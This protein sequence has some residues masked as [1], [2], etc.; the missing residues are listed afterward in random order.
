MAFL[1]RL[2]GFFQ[3]GRIFRASDLIGQVSAQTAKIA[4]DGTYD[5][6]TRE[7]VP[8]RIESTKSLRTLFYV[9]LAADELP[10]YHFWTVPNHPDPVRAAGLMTR[11]AEVEESKT[12]E[13]H[14]MA[15]D[16]N[17][18]D[19]GLAGSSIDDD[20]FVEPPELKAAK[21]REPAPTTSKDRASNPQDEKH[22]QQLTSV[23]GPCNKN[24]ARMDGL[25]P[26]LQSPN[27]LGGLGYARSMN[28]PGLVHNSPKAETNLAEGSTAEKEANPSKKDPV[29]STPPSRQSKSSNIL[30]SIFRPDLSSADSTSSKRG[31]LAVA[32][33]PYG[34]QHRESSI[35]LRFE[36]GAMY[37]QELS[38]SAFVELALY[39]ISHEKDEMT[40]GAG[41]RFL[42]IL[43]PGQSRPTEHR[44]GS[45]IQG[46]RDFNREIKPS[47]GLPDHHF[48][49]RS[50]AYTYALPWD[51]GQPGTLRFTR[52]GVGYCY[53]DAVGSWNSS[54]SKERG[55][56]SAEFQN[57]L[58]FLFGRDKSGAKNEVG[59]EP[60][61]LTLQIPSQS[62]A[63]DIERVRKALLSRELGEI[64][65]DLTSSGLI[66]SVSSEPV[67]WKYS[68][69]V[70]VHERGE[71]FVH[72]DKSTTLENELPKEK[73]REAQEAHLLKHQLVPEHDGTRHTVQP[74]KQ[75]GWS[76]TSPMTVF[77]IVGGPDTPSVRPRVRAQSET[78]ELERRL[79][80]ADV[81]ID[82]M[83]L[84]R[85]LLLSKLQS[86]E[87]QVPSLENQV[88]FLTA[89]NERLEDH[90]RNLDDRVDELEQAGG[91]LQTQVQ[92]LEGRAELFVQERDQL[93]AGVDTLQEEAVQSTQDRELLRLTLCNLENET[94]YLKTGRDELESRVNGLESERDQLQVQ[95]SNLRRRISTGPTSSHAITQTESPQP[96]SQPQI[97]RK[98]AAIPSGGSAESK[99]L[100]YC[101]VCLSSVDKLNQNVR[102]DRMK[103]Y[104]G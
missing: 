12:A 87:G 102:T 54:D 95:V 37:L 89:E 71:D 6:Q 8:A 63:I 66:T 42:D 85:G 78:K 68:A 13:W 20:L 18:D 35:L 101:M 76:T 48:R 26:A 74:P 64:L 38:N 75:G 14:S 7:L 70:F 39:L 31:K 62:K 51:I 93:R 32:N 61:L 98:S 25:P 17:G 3:N 21:S 44:V 23:L 72:P 24:I 86:F 90:I 100:L 57:A 33:G 1:G 97:V 58:N 15:L 30:P 27:Q 69:E 83:H 45:G 77:E 79:G 52:L 65:H 5:Y 4:L 80:L 59:C 28:I 99:G 36:W 84:V 50:D 11:E 82:R 67:P 60:K 103:L 29:T 47:L 22:S 9:A 46:S 73:S 41:Q 91:Q 81:E 53:I 49:I 55:K 56:N 104:P 10:S 19:N 40:I 34:K 94:Q 2:A 88:H 96:Q 92:Q 16:T 43:K